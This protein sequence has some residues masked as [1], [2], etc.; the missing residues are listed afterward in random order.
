VERLSYIW[1]KIWDTWYRMRALLATGGVNLQPLI[2][3]ELPLEEYERGFEL[4]QSR[5]QVVGK[6][7]L[8]P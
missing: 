8:R 3:H 4:M 2:T 6:V 1:R 5:D 7:I